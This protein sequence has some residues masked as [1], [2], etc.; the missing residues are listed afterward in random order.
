[1]CFPFSTT[2]CFVQPEETEAQGIRTRRAASGGWWLFEFNLV[3]PVPV[4]VWERDGWVLLDNGIYTA[5]TPLSVDAL[6]IFTG[7]LCLR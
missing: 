5:M 2:S 7:P 3:E 6:A 1:M 4:C